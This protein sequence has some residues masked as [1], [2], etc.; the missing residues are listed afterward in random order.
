MLVIP[1][2]LVGPTLTLIGLTVIGTVGYEVIDERYSLL[3]SVYM[4]LITITTVGYQEVHPLSGSGRIFTML[5]LLGGVL[6]FFWAAGEVVQV[7]V[8]GQLQKALR[9]RR[10]ERSLND[11]DNHFI[12]C[13]YGRMGRH[14]SMHFSEHGYPF[15]I[16][17][18]NPDLLKGFSL[19]HGIPLVGD[20]SSDPILKKARIDRARALITV[21]GDDA[22]N[23]FITLSARL[24]NEKLY[25]VSRA[26]DESTQEKL[27]RA[28]ASRVV[29]PYVLGGVSIAQAVLRPTVVEFIDLATGSEHIELQMEEVHLKQGSSLIGMP[30]MESMLRKQHGIFIIAIKKKSG[31]MEYNP[32]GDTV[33][34]IGDTLVALG[35]RRELDYLKKVA[36]GKV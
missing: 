9:R 13:G 26:E 27:L 10:M 36:S 16:I 7:V 18:E 25:V 20:A 1:R 21:T 14:V 31:K 8:S 4:T 33:L 17:D 3:D 24:L 34:E 12:V 22:D 19:R 28:G 29:T 35:H 2:A 23:L 30:I 15:V 6:T 5:L 32:P 11:L